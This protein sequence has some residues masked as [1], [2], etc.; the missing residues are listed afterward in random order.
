MKFTESEILA[1][2]KILLDSRALMKTEMMGILDK[3][4][5]N[6]VSQDKQK[7]VSE[8][9]A[10]ER[11][12]YVEPHHGT[13]FLDK[14]WEIGKAVRE[15][16]V[17]EVEY[18]KL[19][20][21]K[22]VHRILQPLALIFSEYYFYLVAFIQNIDRE[23]EFDNTK[24]PFP[25]IYRLDRIRNLRVTNTRFKIPYRDRFEE[26]EFRKR[27]QFMYGGRM[28]TVK[29]EYYGM[30]VEA[31]LDRLPTAKILSE[32]SGKYVIQAEVF[33]NGIDMWLNSRAIISEYWR[34]NIGG[35]EKESCH[36][37]VKGLGYW[38]KSG[39]GN[40]SGI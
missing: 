26:G 3:L 7:I 32:D 37:N 31:V 23:A 24:D 22:T 27:I 9:I 14:M 39:T 19:K 36:R 21:C 4:I 29:F 33:G 15:C 28:K 38:G 40:Y 5:E 20:D 8:L 17:I 16:R 30:S 2:S 10:N 34:G 6:C 18:G 11:F 25:T 12:H 35:E 13:V 1:V